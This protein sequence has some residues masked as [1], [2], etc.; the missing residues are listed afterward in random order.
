MKKISKIL[1]GFPVG[2]F[3]LLITYLI[4]NL[5]DGEAVYAQ[6]ITKLLE[7]SYFIKLFLISGITYMLMF[8]LVYSFIEFAS[9]DNK[10]FWKD[11]GHTIINYILIIV[12]CGIIIHFI[13]KESTYFGEVFA[14]ITLLL[15]VI[16]VVGYII[17]N[18]IEDGKINKALQEIQKE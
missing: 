3:M 15:M 1:I 8:G 2:N 6:E 16:V 11:V 14:G 17:Y 9:K 5:V 12:V 7:G 13:E 10:S 4:I 18:R